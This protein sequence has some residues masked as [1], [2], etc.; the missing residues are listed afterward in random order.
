MKTITMKVTV[1]DEDAEEIA[2]SARK[3]FPTWLVEV[4]DKKGNKKPE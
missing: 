1:K 4:K 3:H 2:N